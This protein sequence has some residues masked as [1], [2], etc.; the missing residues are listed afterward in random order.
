MVV[1]SLAAA[2]A[3]GVYFKLIGDR[4]S[5]KHR[6]ATTASTSSAASASGVDVSSSLMALLRSECLVA[7][8]RW[9]LMQRGG[10]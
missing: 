1:P 10:Q 4:H 9:H 7:S 8:V 6:H 2:T 3:L 5:M